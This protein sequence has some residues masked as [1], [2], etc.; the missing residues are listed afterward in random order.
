MCRK[1]DDDT[2]TTTTTTNRDKY[3]KVAWVSNDSF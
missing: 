2:T 3:V 1:G